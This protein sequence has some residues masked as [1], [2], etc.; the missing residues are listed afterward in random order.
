MVTGETQSSELFVLGFRQCLRKLAACTTALWV[1]QRR[2]NELIFNLHNTLKGATGQ[3]QKQG[4]LMS[5][6]K[7]GL[8]LCDSEMVWVKCWFLQ[9][10]CFLIFIEEPLQEEAWG[11]WLNKSTHGIV[12]F[13]LENISS[14]LLWLNIKILHSIMI[15]SEKKTILSLV[16]VD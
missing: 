4:H 15:P 14:S 9:G 7:T 1:L 6:L 3:P 12:A 16:M 5:F 10:H 13:Q 2:K 11:V 8:F